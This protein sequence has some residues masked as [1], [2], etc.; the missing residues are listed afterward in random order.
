L[1]TTTSRTAP[2]LDWLNGNVTELRDR[3]ER[4]RRVP[5]TGRDSWST[6]EHC[7]RNLRLLIQESSAVDAGDCAIVYFH[8]GG[9]IVGSPETHADVSRAL[10]ENTGLRVISVDYRLAPEHKAPAPIDDGL[11]TLDHLFAR[12]PDEGGLR[13]AILCGDSAGGAIALA[14]GCCATGD[15]KERILG[16]CSLY[17]CFGLTASSSLHAFGNREQGIDADCVHRYWRLAHADTGRSPYSIAALE[18]PSRSRV[19]LLIAGRDPLRDDSLVLVRALRSQGVVV[20]VYFHKH[21]G[22]GFL[23]DGRTR[24][25]VESS[26]AGVSRWM[27]ALMPR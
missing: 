12:D 2:G 19:C 22:H 6:I 23:Q 25:S 18:G 1:R 24:A 20:T 21:E 14:V 7:G 16:V 8:G 10:C 9:W 27:R 3:Y 13:Q 15:V 4:S 17:G 5:L 11:A 26:L